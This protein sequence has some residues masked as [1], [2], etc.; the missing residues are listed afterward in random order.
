MVFKQVSRQWWYLAAG[1]CRQGG[2]WK[3]CLGEVRNFTLPYL[4]LEMEG[5]RAFLLTGVDRVK[6]QSQ[7]RPFRVMGPQGN[8]FLR[9]RD[10]APAELPPSPCFPIGRHYPARGLKPFE[11]RILTMVD[12]PEEFRDLQRKKSKTSK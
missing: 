2:G 12:M 9:S 10:A 4:G 3:K 7:A 8:S 1:R 5:K 6:H 11:H